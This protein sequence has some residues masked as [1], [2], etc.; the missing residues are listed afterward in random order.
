MGALASLPAL[1][2]QVAAGP[3]ERRA[4]RGHPPL[5][6]SSTGRDWATVSPDRSSVIGVGLAGRALSVKVG[7]NYVGIPPD[8]S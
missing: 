6:V 3:R 7:G 2:L 5:L 1:L 8:P 4:L